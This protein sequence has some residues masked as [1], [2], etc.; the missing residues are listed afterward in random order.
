MTP[1]YILA[2]Y[3]PTPP[4]VVEHMIRLA[5]VQSGDMVYD[6]GCGDGRIAIAAAARG[7]RC[8]GVDVEAYW[9]E[10]SRQNALAAGVS[11][12]AQFEHCDAT[13]LDL[14][15]A[16]VVFLY[17]VHWSTQRLADA[18]GQQC[19]PGT[20]VVSHSFPFAKVPA[21]KTESLVD[22]EGQTRHVHLWV[23]GS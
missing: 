18:I 10:Q 7:A 16:N 20:R 22:A 19:A 14:R 4:E 12:L 1:R 21:V 11:H 15:P 9:V 17:L 8:L 6:I 13:E 23:T 2:N 5:D 3:V